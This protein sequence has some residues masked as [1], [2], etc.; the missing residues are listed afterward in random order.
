MHMCW[1]I[2]SKIADFLKISDFLNND[3][4][5]YSDNSDT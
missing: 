5:T 1:R 2:F 4:S 3:T